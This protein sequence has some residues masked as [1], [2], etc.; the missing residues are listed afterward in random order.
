MST[1]AISEGR[2]LIKTH[3]AL[4]R[5]GWRLCGLWVLRSSR[6]FCPFESAIIHIKKRSQGIQLPDVLSALHSEGVLYKVRSLMHGWDSLLFEFQG[7]M[8]IWRGKIN[9]SKPCAA[10]EWQCTILPSY[11]TPQLVV[12]SILYPPWKFLCFILYPLVKLCS[13]W[14]YTLHPWLFIHDGIPGWSSGSS[15]KQKLSCA[16]VPLGSLR[17]HLIHNGEHA[18]FIRAFVG[19]TTI[20]S[21][22]CQLPRG[23]KLFPKFKMETL[24]N[25]RF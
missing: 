1:S 11:C 7:L 9:P 6:R 12:N 10:A 24:F 25:V 23:E 20:S 2:L 13:Y 4:S 17:P 3:F 14:D 15:Q 19:Q 22:G 21:G 8:G 18:Q 5:S 16:T